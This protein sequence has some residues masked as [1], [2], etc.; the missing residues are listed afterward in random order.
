MIVACGSK[1]TS[2]LPATQPIIAR[3]TPAPSPATT[4]SKTPTTTTKAKTKTVTHPA[5]ATTT[6]TATTTTP[7]NNVTGSV[8]SD[9]AALDTGDTT[10]NKATVRLYKRAIDDLRKSCTNAREQIGSYAV[11]IVQRARQGT[12]RPN[13]LAVLQ[14]VKRAIGRSRAPNSPAADCAPVFSA[15]LQILTGG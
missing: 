8:E 14:G 10:P 1:D 12:S 15:Y 4:V 6:P 2:T 9:L 11:Q 3:S 7:R 13:N 5:P